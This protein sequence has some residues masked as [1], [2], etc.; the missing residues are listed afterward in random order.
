M[1]STIFFNGRVI[2]TPGSYSEIDVSGL[3]SIGLGAAGIV[4][5]IGEGIGGKPVSELE[6][7]SDFLR[8][9]KPEQA[10]KTFKSGDLREAIPMAFSPS[11]DPD[12]LGGA[13]EIVAMKVNPATASELTLENT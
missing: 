2:A 9:T 5:I 12:I 1:A 10:L 6:S 4:A 7:V 3:E 8:F 13:Q 11:N